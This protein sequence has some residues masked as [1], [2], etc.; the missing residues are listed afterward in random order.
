[1]FDA[2]KSQ[3]SR[4][5]SMIV[6]S[7]ILGIIASLLIVAGLKS[8]LTEQEMGEW[9]WRIP[10]LVGV[11]NI[12][13][14]LYLRLSLP[15]LPKTQRLS[16]RSSSSSILKVF[17]IAV[18]GA[19]IFYTQDLASGILG[20]AMNIDN[21]ALINTTML[22]LFLFISHLLWIGFN[23]HKAMKFGTTVLLL[24]RYHFFYC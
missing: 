1:M 17:S 4:V 10:L 8:I 19:V 6:G 5:S 3:R 14:S 22:V 7:T 9:G 2:Q 18:L 15:E 12:F 16:T 21:L 20:K 24:Q 23:P 13:V 11:M